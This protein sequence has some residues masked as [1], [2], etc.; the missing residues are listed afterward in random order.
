MEYNY[1]IRP[2]ETVIDSDWTNLSNHI[3]EEEGKIIDRR[4]RWLIFQTQ[5]LD[6]VF[7]AYYQVLYRD[8]NDNRLW[9]VTYPQGFQNG[10]GITKLSCVTAEYANK[11]YTVEKINA[12]ETIIDSNNVIDNEQS[13]QIADRIYRLVHNY[14]H[15]VF[16]ANNRNGLFQDPS[17]KR[18]WELTYTEIHKDDIGL[19]KFTLNNISEADAALKY[20][21]EEIQPD[22]VIIDSN[23]NSVALRQKISRRI[24]Q[25]ENNY[26]E[27]II[28]K[29]WE[30]L[31][32]DPKDNRFWELTYPNSDM[33]GGG[34]PLLKNIDKDMVLSKYGKY[35][36]DKC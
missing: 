31:Y 20:K 35:E 3:S 33:Q 19:P 23:V 2:E 18:L 15:K 24:Y 17:D 13:N 36:V 25:L 10:F 21:V 34:P 27:K 22:E 16:V 11:K 12:Y 1:L 4:I 29:G 28:D 9:E 26:L 6:V 5:Q 32:K 30:V 8:K 7:D 14:L